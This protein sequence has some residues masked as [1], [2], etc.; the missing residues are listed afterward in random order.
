[1]SDKNADPASQKANN[2]L[3]LS[4]L[5]VRRAIGSLGFVLPAALWLFSAT[6]PGIAVLPTMSD[7][8]YTPVGVIFVGILTAIAVFLWSYKGYHKLHD[9]WLSD[10]VVARI[11]SLGALGTGWIPTAAPYPLD[12]CPEITIAPMACT[13]TQHLLTPGPAAVIHLICAGVFFSALAV[14]SLILFTRGTE[15]STEKRAS[16]RIY[17]I[18]GWVIVAAMVGIITLK[19]FVPTEAAIR[20]A[21]P[22]FWLETI[23]CMAFATSWAVKGDA[24]RL[25]VRMA[26]PDG[27]TQ[28]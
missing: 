20:T 24:L 21:A 8:Y 10:L 28:P 11:A 3:V 16:N 1:M 18:C 13:F 26:A 5:S 17:R 15:D 23:A 9:E 12:S 27:P 14:F 2:D 7:Y 4:F 22:V 6:Q 19:L 25:L